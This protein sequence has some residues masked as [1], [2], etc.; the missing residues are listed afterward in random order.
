MLAVINVL[1]NSEH[2]PEELF[3]AHARWL[4]FPIPT[5]WMTDVGPSFCRL[6]VSKW[7]TADYAGKNP[8]MNSPMRAMTGILAAVQLRILRI[9]LGE[10]GI[11]VIFRA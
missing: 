10:K 7:Q 2:D 9:V 6:I 4:R 3:V 8:L 11:G 1:L 5:P